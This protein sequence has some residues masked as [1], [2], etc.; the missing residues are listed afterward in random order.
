MKK[1][2]KEWMEGNNERKEK[3]SLREESITR[4]EVYSRRNRVE[5]RT[6]EEGK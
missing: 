2:R 5:N 4:R 1:E 6:K 3:E